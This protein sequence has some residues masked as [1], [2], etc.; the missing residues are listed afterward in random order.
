MYRK[1]QIYTL[2]YARRRIDSGTSS[3]FLHLVFYAL[4]CKRVAEK[5]YLSSS[6]SVSLCIKIIIRIPQ[7]YVRRYIYAVGIFINK[8]RKVLMWWF[9]SRKYQTQWRWWMRLIERVEANFRLLLFSLSCLIHW[10]RSVDVR[11][12][13]CRFLYNQ[14]PE[15]PLLIWHLIA[16]V[17]LTHTLTYLSVLSCCSH[18]H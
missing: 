10:S 17:D 15:L 6:L 9:F 1:N 11:L 4:W 7:W 18:R 16:N 13:I 12:L 5:T 2:L 14:S 8:K 3:L